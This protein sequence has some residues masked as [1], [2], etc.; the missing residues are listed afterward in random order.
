[1]TPEEQGEEC[2]GKGGQGELH[3]EVILEQT[4]EKVSTEPGEHLGREPLCLT[5]ASESTFP[6]FLGFL[7][8]FT[9]SQQGKLKRQ[10]QP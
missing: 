8:S 4:L 3:E 7:R 5:P 10:K 6:S 9:Y 2:F 1:M